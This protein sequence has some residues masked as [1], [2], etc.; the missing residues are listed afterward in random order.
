MTEKKEK[1]EKE[2][3]GEE[4]EEEK[5]LSIKENANI[6]WD[7]YVSSPCNG[8]ND[9]SIIW[10]RQQEGEQVWRESSD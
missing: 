8:Q 5:E 3:E 9:D 6:S 7:S 2:E 10:D 4:E 1:E